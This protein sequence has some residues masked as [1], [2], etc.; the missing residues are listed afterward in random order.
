MRK[1]AKSS[2]KI[3]TGPLVDLFDAY[4]KNKHNG[5]IMKLIPEIPQSDCRNKDV[6]P[7]INAQMDSSKSPPRIY[8]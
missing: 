1:V 4:I 2:C 3:R 7:V 6:E 8:K 5:M